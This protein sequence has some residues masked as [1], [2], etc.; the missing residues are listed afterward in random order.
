MAKPRPHEVAAGFPPAIPVPTSTP[1]GTRKPPA[2]APWVDC[3][4]CAWRHYPSF[5]RNGWTLVAT[6]GNCDSPLAEVV[7]E[8]LK[9]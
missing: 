5:E 3:P 1:G 9:R 8:T 6:C 4:R 7:I 2:P